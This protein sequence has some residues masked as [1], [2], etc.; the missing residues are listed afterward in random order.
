M[1]APQVDT[2]LDACQDAALGAAAW[3]DALQVLA[4]A[5]GARSCVLLPFD[6]DLSV[7]RRRQFESRSHSRFTAVWL[8]RVD[9]APDPHTSR[10]YSVPISKHP[11]VTE[12]QITNT[13]ERSTLPYYRSIATAGNRTWWA[14]IRF[15]TH[16][17]RWALPL[18]RTKEQG[19]FTVQDVRKLDALMPAVRRF[20]SSAEMME[21]TRLSERLKSFSDLGCAAIL[22]DDRGHVIRHNDPAAQLFGPDLWICRGQIVSNGP[23]NNQQLKKITTRSASSNGFPIT[24]WRDGTPWLIAQSVT[25][26]SLASDVFS[27]G[28]RLLLL[29]DV[30]PTGSVNSDYLRMAFALTPAEARLASE[31]VDGAGLGKASMAIGIGKET[32]RTH[33][34]AIFGKTGTSSQAQ[35][36]ALLSRVF[37]N[38]KKLPK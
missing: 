9:E 3:D 29:Q 10:P 18:Y 6:Q 37:A 2:A 4:E 23:V 11:T 16:S 5:V 7:R 26:S 33:L 8:D 25:L 32:G 13:E 19:P 31:L 24:L 20:V 17:R 28:K 38:W 30:L 1:G 27:G 12:H 34:S 14:A 36:A 21:E 22:L 15:E 35:L